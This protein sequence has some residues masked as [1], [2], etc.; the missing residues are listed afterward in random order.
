MSTRS[1]LTIVGMWLVVSVGSGVF[2]SAQQQNRPNVRQHLNLQQMPVSDEAVPEATLTSDGKGRRRYTLS[3]I[4]MSKDR[5]TVIFWVIDKRSNRYA[6]LRLGDDVA[7]E[8]KRISGMYQMLGV[9]V[10]PSDIERH[11]SAVKADAEAR[12]RRDLERRPARRLAERSHDAGSGP[13]A[14]VIDD[15]AIEEEC[16]G[17]GWVNIKTYEPAAYVFPVSHLNETSVNGSW[18]RWPASGEVW[19]TSTGGE[20]WAN[21]ETFAYTTWFTKE[22]IPQ[23]IEKAVN[24]ID[25]STIGIYHN[26]DFFDDR[27]SVQVEHT[28]AVMYNGSEPR[29]GMQYEEKDFYLGYP[30]ST[31]TDSIFISGQ[32]AGY[33][34]EDCTSEP[35]DPMPAPGSACPECNSPLILD[36]ARNGFDLT[37]AARGVQ[38]DLDTNGRDELIAWTRAGSDDAFLAMDRN[39]NGR[40]DNGA[41]LFGNHTPPYPSKNGFEALKALDDNR[42]GVIDNS[43]RAFAQLLAWTDSNHNGVS[44]GHELRALSSVGL[45]AIR[46]DYS[47]AQKRDRYGNLFL[48]RAKSVWEERDGWVY[49][50]W[51]LRVQ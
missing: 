38:F 1:L 20:C 39:G 25:I 13:S 32:T 23:R 19:A 41:E 5:A 2:L 6:V 47:S 31:G 16:S 28:A 22:C 43:D 46:T 37:D 51:L 49:D 30:A 15:M 45:I 14:V 9:R 48:Q 27:W 42:D 36:V 50:V 34:F 18:I 35:E 24:F 26:Y 12:R 17:G 33:A 11:Y 40:I 8:A 7:K 4:P 21:P 10:N 29:T 3:Q 44:E